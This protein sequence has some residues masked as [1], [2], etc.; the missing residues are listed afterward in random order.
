MKN[1]ENVTDLRNDLMDVYNAVRNKEIG[2][3]EAKEVANVAG[4]ILSSC[5]VQMEYNKY[6]GSKDS[7]HFLQGK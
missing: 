1:I 2:L 5:K 3:S 4:K 6:V 7:I